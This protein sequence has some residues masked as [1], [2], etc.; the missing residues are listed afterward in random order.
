MSTWGQ[1]VFDNDAAL[2]WLNSLQK[3]GFLAITTP[4]AEIGEYSGM[5]VDIPAETEQSFWASCEII[6]AA[7][8]YKIECIN[9]ETKTLLATEANKILNIPNLKQRIEY[10]LEQ[11]FKNET[12]LEQLWNSSGEGLEFKELRNNIRKKVLRALN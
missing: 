4:I 8:G 1:G 7:A 12:E 3:L 11:L 6:A 5:S 9:T 2:D 10:A